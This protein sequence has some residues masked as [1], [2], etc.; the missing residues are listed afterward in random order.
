M[1]VLGQIAELKT[2]PIAD[3]KAKWRELHGSEA[4]PYNRAFL[5]SG[6]AT[7]SKNCATAD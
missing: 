1:N 2:M 7:G 3:L 6:S 5:E 4:P